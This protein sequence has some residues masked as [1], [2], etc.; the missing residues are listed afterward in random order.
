MVLQTAS[1]NGN[2]VNIFIVGEGYGA[3]DIANGNYMDRVNE[4]LESLF[5]IEPYKTYRNLFSVSTS[6][7]LSPDN[8][9]M[10][11]LTYKETKF[12][13]F[14]PQIDCPFVSELTY[15]L[16][17]YVKK[18]SASID[19]SNIDKCLIVML[20]NYDS[21]AGSAYQCVDDNCSIA[22]IGNSKDMYPLDNR[23]LVLRYAGGSAFA[24]LASEEI[25]HMETIKGCTCPSCNGLSTYRTM[26]EKGLF[27]NVTISAKIE[28]SPWRDFMFHPKYSGIVDMYE[29]GFNHF[30]G[31][32]RSENESVMNTYIPY[33]NT[34][35]RYAIYNRIMLRAG[36]TPTIDDFISN[37]KIE[38]P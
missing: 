15:N 3:E 7:A 17:E 2:P 8:G 1:G 16:K 25:S 28:D 30:R 35:S 29:G 22:F 37:D 10:D 36:L 23:A 21:F 26:K 20:A 32:W 38:I 34:V 4:T 6:L 13:F 31:V 11:V 24:G 5:S 33:Y 19:D 18:V 27:E 12:G 9:A 14:F